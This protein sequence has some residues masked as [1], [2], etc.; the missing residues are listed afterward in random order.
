MTFSLSK[1]LYNI[2]VFAVPLN[3]NSFF[4]FNNLQL[5]IF[6]RNSPFIGK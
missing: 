3:I 5:N 6:F 1:I 2:S 4:Y